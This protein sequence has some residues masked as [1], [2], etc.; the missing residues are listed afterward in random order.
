MRITFFTERINLW[1][2]LPSYIVNSSLVNSFK[3][4]MDNCL[5][6]QDVNYDY[7]CDIAGTEN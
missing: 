7:K 2:S 1:N 4:N 6:S 3:T 5:H